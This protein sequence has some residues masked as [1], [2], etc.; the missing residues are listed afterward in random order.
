[1]GTPT[2]YPQRMPRSPW[3]PNS[4]QTRLLAALHRAAEKRAAAEAEL[5]AAL[6][7]CEQADIPIAR[8][9]KELGVERKTVYRYLGRPMK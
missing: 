6:A 1:M 2:G 8:L 3:S 5:R 4:D 9:A 7:A